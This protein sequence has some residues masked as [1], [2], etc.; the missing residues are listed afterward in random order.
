MKPDTIQIDQVSW[1]DAGA[2]L[3]AIRRQVFIIEQ[4]VPEHEEL[5]DADRDCDHFLARD[6]QGQLLGCARLTPQG[7]IGRMAVLEAVRG[8]RIGQ[9]LLEAVI[10]HARTRGFEQVFLHAQTHALEF[11]RKAGFSVRGDRFLDA[12]IEHLEMILELSG[13]LRP[14]AFANEA[15]AARALADCLSAPSRHLEILHPTLEPELFATPAFCDGISSF[16][17]G[18]Q[19]HRIRILIY[20]SHRIVT[21][22]NRLVELARR[23]DSR[24]Q[25]R[26]VPEEYATDERAFLCWDAEGYWLLPNAESYHG[27]LNAND[28]VM[29][30]RL[31]E[32]F[33]YLWERAKVDPELRLLKL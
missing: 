25:I 9:A 28:P 13:N 21:G 15:D 6:G 18:G 7:Q 26:R 12:G 2:D 24:I 11:Y 32:R 3:S 30:R 29:A 23:L 17:R 27:L 10:D 31:T 8:F 22:G 1:A 16:A 4:G 5:E 14:T 20:S 33:D 19:R